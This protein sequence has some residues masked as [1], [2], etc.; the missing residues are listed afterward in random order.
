MNG[1]THRLVTEMAIQY[2]ENLT[3]NFTLN[4]KKVKD[5]SQSIQ[6][7]NSDTDGKNDFEKEM[8]FV[9]VEGGAGDASDNPHK[10]DTWA[11]DDKAKYSEKGYTFASFNHFIDI[12]KG[13]GRYDDYD[14]YSYQ[15]GSAKKDQHEKLSNQVSDSVLAGLLNVALGAI[16]KE[17]VDAGVVGYW[18][19]DEY[20]HAPG[21]KWYRNC[22]P[23]AWNYSFPSVL[24]SYSDKYAEFDKR[25]PRTTHST[26]TSGKGIPYSVFMPVDNLGRYWYERYMLSNEPADLGP[27]LHAVQDAT[28]PH[29]ATGYMGNYHVYYESELEKY[30][31][32]ICKSANFKEETLK[33][34]NLWMK[35]SGSVSSLIY[36][37]DR[38]K[39]PG[40]GWRIDYLIT[41]LAFKA[42]YAY[43]NVYQGFKNKAFNEGSAK[44]LLAMACAMSM[45]TIQKAKKEIESAPVG[46][47]YHIKEV[48][49]TGQNNS[50]KNYTDEM[51][52]LFYN[53]AA[54]EGGA[55]TTKK[56]K[57][58]AN[59]VNWVAKVN[60]SCLNLDIRKVYIAINKEGQKDWQI[61][62]VTVSCT[63]DN[64]SQI[65]YQ[66]D[67]YWN[68]LLN[69]KNCF[70]IPK[71]SL[72]L[73]T[74]D[75]TK[76]VGQIKLSLVTS[77]LKNASLN[78]QLALIAQDGNMNDKWGYISNF[79]NTSLM[80]GTT[81][82]E[83]FDL[84]KQ[85]IQ[86]RNLK[87]EIWNR[88]KNAWLPK[89]ITVEVYEAGTG[90]LLRKKVIAWNSQ[91]WFSQNSKPTSLGAS[92]HPI[93]FE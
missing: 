78:G 8:E 24:R 61:D 90:K 68:K 9:D 30:A 12:K 42:Y 7:K 14:G 88:S 54:G 62:R 80:A 49:V 67:Y 60:V 84:S 36:E 85:E 23:A 41:W 2:L 39:T 37:K 63:M 53:N 25:F 82:K 73:P 16:G 51:Q 93:P 15:Y 35:Q 17:K 27:A 19:N 81:V 46:R 29:H 33:Y 71:S 38:N 3:P 75:T 86:L 87:L 92:Q 13:S 40:S 56:F 79:K 72:V 55:F 64:G 58:T 20:V 6:Q 44:D 11:I 74:D 21:Q 43:E 26:G 57:P 5:Y 89:E 77:T 52:L 83:Q 18:M 32:K 59:G 47:E 70:V 76:K 91:R 31:D 34:Y 65:Y 22:S 10:N 69:E 50:K 45:V 66:R 1:K 48:T 28:I 4:G